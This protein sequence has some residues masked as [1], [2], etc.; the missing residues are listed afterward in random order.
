MK[1]PVRHIYRSYMV[2]VA[3]MV[4]AIALKLLIDQWAPLG[5][6]APFLVVTGGVMVAAWWGGLGPGLLA[7]LLGALA[8]PLLYFEAAYPF[9]AGNDSEAMRLVLFLAEG[10]LVSGLAGS[11]HAARRRAI[12][13]AQALEDNERQHR[14]TF[15]QA[16]VGI[17]HSTPDGRW[18]RANRRFCEITGYERDEVLSLRVADIVQLADIERESPLVRELVE[19]TRQSFNIEKQY[20]NKD[21]ELIWVD[22]TS[23]VVR[24]PEGEARYFIRVVEDITRRKDAE[25][26]IRQLTHTLEERV[27]ERTAVAEHRAAQLRKLAV[28]LTGAEQRERRRL[29]QLLHDH[30]Q[31]LLV[32]SKLR[33]GLLRKRIDNGLVTAITDI[34]DL[35]SQSIDAS[36]SLT[37]ELSPPILYD[38]GLAPALSWLA[39][40]MKSKHN[41]DVTVNVEV[42]EPQL[43][44]ELAV[45]LFHSVRE[46][47]FNVVKHSGVSEATVKLGVEQERLLCIEV[48]DKGRGFESDSGEAPDAGGDGL[49]LFGIRERLEMLGGT[50][51]IDNKPGQGASAQIC[52]PLDSVDSRSSERALEAMVETDSESDESADSATDLGDA[53]LDV[54]LDMP[55]PG[56]IVIRVLLVDD[57]PILRQGMATLLNEQPDIEVIG[58]ASDGIMAVE[59]ALALNPDVVIMDVTLPRLNGIQATRRIRENKKD[60]CI[61][62]LSMHEKRDMA[63]AM[64]EAGASYYLSKGGPSELLVAAI[65]RCFAGSRVEAAKASRISTSSPQSEVVTD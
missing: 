60:A 45:F 55:P 36:R 14:V 37:M 23:A 65:R 12:D 1:I 20:R 22:V 48:S 3:I 31:Q 56:P 46:L 6:G 42:E 16:P 38:R 34:D 24:S 11:F 30:L 63:S 43:R 54:I 33:L 44:Q 52:V 9:G 17:A 57:H 4:S 64:R 53:A 32:A 15:E 50:L 2:A 27:A 18:L 51:S 49:G 26:A 62:G 8:V 7:T 61:I 59:M 41:L 29:A 35:I 58:E 13:Q 21:G 10:A 25:A 47:L 28:E 39:R 19:G 40:D 5:H